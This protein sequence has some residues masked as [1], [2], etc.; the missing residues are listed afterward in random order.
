MPFR[1]NATGPPESLSVPGDY[2]GDTYRHTSVNWG[3]ATAPVLIG[4]EGGPTVPTIPLTGQTW[5]R[6]N[7]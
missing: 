2:L 5:P 7:Y 6:G 4:G 1:G 3:H